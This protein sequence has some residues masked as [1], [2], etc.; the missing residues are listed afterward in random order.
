MVLESETSHNLPS[1]FFVLSPQRK[2]EPTEVVP[3]PGAV[4][5]WISASARLT[6]TYIILL[7]SVFWPTLALAQQVCDEK[8]AAKISID[9]GHPWRPP[10]GLDR[11]GSLPV[12]R[13]ELV[14]Q[15]DP[16]RE[17]HLTT[18]RDGRQVER[19]KL[20]FSRNPSHYA[21]S[22]FATTEETPSFFAHAPLAAVPSEVAVLAQ[23]GGQSEELARQSVTWPEIEA[24]V[25]ARPDRRIN[26]VDLGT[27]LP[28]HDWLLL[29]GGQTA[30]IDVAA[31]SHARDLPNAR[32]RA[33][34]T[35]G[36]PVEVDLPL[37]QNQKVT[38]ELKLPLSAKGDRATLYVS[39]TD[40][41][42]ELWKKEIRTMIVG[43]AP[44]WP[45]FG[46][47]ETK[48]RYDAPIVTVDPRTG[49]VLPSIDY[50]SAWN[51]KLKDVVVFLPNGS[52]FVF[53][54]GSNYIPFWAGRYNTGVLY[55]WAE[56]CSETLLVSHP[57]GSRDCPEPLFDSE[58][59]YSR[60]RIVE[61][62]ASRVHVRWDY[63]LT[64]VRYEV[65]GGAASE[66]FYFYPDGFGTRVVTVPSTPGEMYQ[67]S[68]FIIMTPQA[69]YPFEVLPRHMMEVLPLDG[70]KE[71]IEFPSEPAMR[72]GL[73]LRPNLVEPRRKPMVYRLF[74]HKDDPAAAI[75]FH[76]SDPAVPWAFPPF[77]DKG[78]MVTPVYWGNHWPLNRGKWTG[79]G[80]NDRITITPAH[81][82]VAGFSPPRD[83][84]TGKWLGSWEVKPLM[85]GEVLMPD[86]Q[87]QVRAVNLSRFVWLLAHTDLPDEALRDWGKSFSTPP[88]LEV[89]GARLDLPSY[90]PE[91]RALRL[92][93][94]QP[95]I[96]IKVKP[97]ARTVNPVFEIDQAPK[98]LVGVTLDGKSLPAD[99]YAWDGKVLWIKA[100]I[101]KEGAAISVRFR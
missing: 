9:Q 70:G 74:A 3:D 31:L 71:R 83:P 56:N 88:A 33:W 55:Q 47:V 25:K 23:C 26:P 62:S 7:A 54:R 80:I 46:A 68:E 91:R 89:A 63:Q 90:S 39:L 81:N 86:V 92:V 69:A 12:A 8:A 29:A 94:E 76:P 49:A 10:F 67:L 14:T 66:D 13:V 40:G 18:Y 4:P 79:W 6:G 100:R 101:S 44:S 20:V 77:Y 75:Y 43:K 96:E 72:E 22:G 42:R 48:L 52:R 41:A 64:D 45:A 38:R 50:D 60:V 65:W 17:Y 2:R 28:P 57:D 36:R 97:Q 61:S 24:D 82:S 5:S 21:G 11:V 27:I 30:V 84:E 93:A 15:R 35:G 51:E 16:S 59:R 78:E 32:L 99:A 73:S 95:A 1:V 58:L 37:P 19:Y 85:S 34:F 98:R 87:G 53:W